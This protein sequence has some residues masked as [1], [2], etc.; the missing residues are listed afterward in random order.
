MEEASQGEGAAMEEEASQVDLFKKV[1]EDH[2]EDLRRLLQEF[3]QKAGS[4][5]PRGERASQSVDRSGKP[6]FADDGGAVWAHATAAP[7]KPGSTAQMGLS[8]LTSDAL[9]GDLPQEG[10][11]LAIVMEVARQALEDAESRFP[12]GAS[13]SQ[14]ARLETSLQHCQGCSQQRDRLRM[15]D[16]EGPQG[17]NM[18]CLCLLTWQ[19]RCLCAELPDEHCALDQIIELLEFTHRLC[20]QASPAERTRLDE[21]PRR[22]AAPPCRAPGSQQSST[23]GTMQS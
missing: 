22:A 14:E 6:E 1:L 4:D 9:R 15:Q 13:A 7:E 5:N 19:I 21:R 2:V 10:G 20:T 17:G 11:P 3:S 23:S 12:P 16:V 18:C 8:P